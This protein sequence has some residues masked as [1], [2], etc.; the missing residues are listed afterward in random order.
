MGE[1]SRAHTWRR[2]VGV[3]PVEPESLSKLTRNNRQASV[4]SAV[5]AVTGDI[6]DGSSV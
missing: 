2:D 1:G 5:G 3:S 4:G 6:G